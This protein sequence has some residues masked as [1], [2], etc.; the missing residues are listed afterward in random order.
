MTVKAICEAIKTAADQATRHALPAIPAI[1]MLCSLAKR[2]GLST[3]MSVINIVQECKKYG[4]PTE[5]NEDGSPNLYMM[6]TKS[7]INEAYRAIRFDM[8]SQGAG[9]PGG[10]SIAATGGN[11]GGPVEV[12]GFNTAPFKTLNLSM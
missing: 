3:I 12:F 6:L 8:N 11:A 2:P 10:V 1:V 4:I 7:I 5:S 9:A